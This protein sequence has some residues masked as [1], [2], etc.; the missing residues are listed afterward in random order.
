M[1][2]SSVAHSCADVCT[3]NLIFDLVRLFPRRPGYSRGRAQFR[4]VAGAAHGRVVGPAVVVV[5]AL[6]VVVA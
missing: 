3:I 2:R 5:V 1:L 6:A 4:G